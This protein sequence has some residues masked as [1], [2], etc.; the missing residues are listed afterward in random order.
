MFVSYDKTINFE[1]KF[2]KLD[3]N[4]LYLYIPGGLSV[5]GP[6]HGMVS[7]RGKKYIYAD[8]GNNYSV[9]KILITLSLYLITYRYAL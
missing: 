3:N 1:N 7:I 2:L 6:T 5:W 9:K 8:I 4:I